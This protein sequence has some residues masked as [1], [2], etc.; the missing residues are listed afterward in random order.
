MDHLGQPD[1]RSVD[2]AAR[3]P[4]TLRLTTEHTAAAVVL[5]ADGEID[6]ATADLFGTSLAGAVGGRPPLLVV[7]LA[8][9]R[10]LSCG[11]L[12]V[13]VAA[14]RLAGAVTR[15]VVVAPTRA[16]R[17]PLF[18]T[19]TARSLTVCRHRDEVMS[20]PLRMR[21]VV[22]GT[23]VLVVA[24]GGSAS[25][26]GRQVTDELREAESAVT[27]F[28]TRPRARCPPE[29]WPPRCGPPT[30]ATAATSAS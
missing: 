11:G 24:I 10:F 23:A 14:H 5:V 2:L 1:L 16:C 4:P 20:P 7:D 12:A 30:A 18:L 26:D 29:Y 27:S 19:D 15:M 3:P 9:V 13:L 17:S 6:L 25:S 28:S 21:T 22:A 8:P